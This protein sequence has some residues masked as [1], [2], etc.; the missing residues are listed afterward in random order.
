M[1]SLDG[2]VGKVGHVFSLAMADF[3]SNSAILR[4][5]WPSVALTATRET[6][7]GREKW[8]SLV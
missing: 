8:Q 3:I 6:A 4:C 5:A 2:S 7:P 1:P